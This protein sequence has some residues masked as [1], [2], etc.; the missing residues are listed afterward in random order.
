MKLLVKDAIHIYNTKR[1]HWS[2]YM[3]TPEQMHKQDR[4]KIRTYKTKIAVGLVR[5]LSHNILVFLSY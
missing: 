5:Q 4:I 1:P 2:G 3:K